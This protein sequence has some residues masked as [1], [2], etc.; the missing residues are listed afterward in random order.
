M[1]IGLDF[2]TT[3]S[4]AALYNGQSVRLLPLDPSAPNPAVCR[5]AVYITRGREYYLGSQAVNLY[6]QQNIG[7]PSRYRKIWVGEIWQVFAELPPFLRDVYVY[8]DEFSPGR[9]FLSIKTILRNANFLG[10]A[11]QEQWFSASDLAAVFLMGMKQRAERHLG[12][13]LKQV[14]LGRPVFF[15]TKADENK[16]AQS[17]LLDAAIKAGFEKVYLEYEP[18]AAALSYE[19]TL[20]APETVLVFD[21]GGGTLDFTIMQ[22]G[23]PS[24]R[25]VLATGGIAVAGDAFD[26]RLFRIAI[27]RHLGEG[28]YF[29]QDGKRYP[30]P[31]HIFDHLTNSQEILAL[32][33]PQNL[34]M[35][36]SIHLG[37][38]N[39]KKTEALLKIIS[40]NYALLLFDV[41]ERAKCQLSEQNEA[42]LSV[43]TQDFSFKEKILRSRFELAIRHEYEAIRQELLQTIERSG[44]RPQDI[45][46]VI[47]T[48]G[49]S[50]IPMFAAMLD[51][52]FGKDKVRA[53]DV[54]SSVTSGL[55]IRAH[56]IERG[57]VDAH[58]WTPDTVKA[59]ESLKDKT[60][61]AG[62]A[63]PVD[64]DL[65]RQR[66][67]VLDEY[68]E[69]KRA[70][71][72]ELCLVLGEG[73]IELAVISPDGP[74]QDWGWASQGLIAAEKQQ[75]LM[76]SDTFK[77]FSRDLTA[78]YL[79]RQTT[80]SGISDLLHLEKSERICA[81]TDW[82]PDQ[83]ATRFCCLVTNLGQMRCF[84]AQLLSDQIR[85]RPFFQLEKRYAGL[86]LALLMTDED[87]ILMI[88]TN[89][90]RIGRANPRH[91]LGIT[92]EMLRP[93]GREMVCAAG[94][95]P[96]EGLL[97]AVD[98][99]GKA[100]V[101]DPLF[102][103][104]EGP[105]AGRGI[106]L[107]RDFCIVSFMALAPASKGQVKAFTSLG[108]LIPITF[109]LTLLNHGAAFQAFQLL[110]GE[111]ILTTIPSNS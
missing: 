66:L 21:F 24:G 83:V 44:L 67:E 101:V 99:H 51:E 48:G 15:S 79:A 12:Q 20:S 96:R 53:I 11:F 46:R 104:F 85:P 65:V 71:P 77:L 34:E 84:E 5:T 31:S 70:V 57:E 98:A 60:G 33:T 62:E 27:P 32:N 3:N 8:E 108:R 86:P 10:T 59:S 94:S 52:L 55:G 37:A 40:S 18:V 80:Q 102:A 17:R 28:D 23:N 97:L 100:I 38:H 2:G 45:Q 75:A 4:G 105:P 89:T 43:V 7:R 74:P 90:G 13:E 87:R 39:K 25:Q 111:K 88:G 26:Q 82:N 109:T 22:V 68:Q 9:L 29:T 63:S 81:V 41:V 16:I 73:K 49:S 54:F 6:F 30:I 56:E 36:R 107:R 106:L 91:G 1:L 72:Q 76:A 110:P 35:L 103:P 93:H 64:L 47:R 69:G 61:K 19:K 92:W 42:E 50:Q 95:F 14:V 58:A 78:M